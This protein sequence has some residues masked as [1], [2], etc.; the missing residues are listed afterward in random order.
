VSDVNSRLWNEIEKFSPFGVG[1]PKPLFYLTQAEL[2]NV[3]IFG[4]EKNHLEL[5]LS[6]GKKKVPAIAFFSAPEDWPNLS[7]G[8]KINVVATLEK[9]NFRGVSEIRLRLV[10]IL[11]EGIN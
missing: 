6:D 5:T 10:D 1:N 8:T 9:S 7:V 3:K 2:V 11:P 4:K